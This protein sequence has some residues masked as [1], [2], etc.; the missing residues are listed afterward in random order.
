MKL[1]KKF[2]VIPVIAALVGAFYALPAN[3][4]TSTDSPTRYI[5][6]NAEGTVSVTPDAVRLNATVTFV[7]ATSKEALA[8]A[9]AAAAKV[10]AA[11]RAKA[12]AAKD[13]KTTSITVYPEYSYTQEQ[14][15]LIS[16]YRASQ[17][18]LVTI[19]SADV[20]GVLVEDI[21][22]AGGNDVQI[23][24]VTP[25]V[26]DATKATLV[27]RAEAV[28][29]A[30]EKAASYASL[31]GIKLGKITYLVENSSPISFPVV[32]GIAKAAD[33]A[34]TEVDLGSQDLTVS[35]TIRW[36]LA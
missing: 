35:I 4:A 19:R 25:F 26:L 36:S 29:Q 17:T 21:V 12:I 27:A 24:S 2:L 34:G 18:F 8:G 6:L 22:N 20:A 28:S 7:G 33:S 10:R 14:G 32:M 5:T 1:N 11:I 31:L 13:L 3:A 30:R 16:G 23:Q 9:S 15:S